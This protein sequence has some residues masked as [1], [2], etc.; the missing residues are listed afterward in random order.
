ML[1]IL[2]TCSGSTMRSLYFYHCLILF[3]EFTVTHLSILASNS[4][5]VLVIQALKRAELFGIPGVTYSLTQVYQ[6]YCRMLVLFS[7]MYSSALPVLLHR[8]Q[9]L[10][11][12]VQF[13]VQ[14]LKCLLELLINRES[15][16]I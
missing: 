1:T 11:K 14:G 8:Y 16:R 15:L 6:T 10:T 5:Y 9:C 2:I 3:I 4:S 13:S 7:V 12:P